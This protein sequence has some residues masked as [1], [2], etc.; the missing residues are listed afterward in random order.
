MMRALKV[1][2]LWTP[3]LKEQGNILMEQEEMLEKPDLAKTDAEGKE[4]ARMN[5]IP[6]NKMRQ[7]N[8]LALDFIQ[9][10]LESRDLISTGGCETAAGV[11]LQ[12]ESSYQ[13]LNKNACDRAQRKFYA[14]KYDERE[15]LSEFFFQI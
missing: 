13:V 8:N 7:Q 10:A 2:N 6:L 5:H 14:L 4:V 9:S 3:C 12:L 1:R 11:W 15:G